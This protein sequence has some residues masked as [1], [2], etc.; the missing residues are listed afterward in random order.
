MKKIAITGG[1]S[2]GKTSVC[3]ILQACGAYVVSADEIV[4]RLLTPETAVGQEVIHL[5]GSE[6][7]SGPKIDRDKIAKKVFSQPELLNRLEQLLHPKVF[8]EIE[9]QY[10][11]ISKERKYT[12]FV[13]EIPLLFESESHHLFDLVIAVLTDEKLAKARYSDSTGK[14]DFESR[15]T[16]QIDPTRKA[17]KAD[18]VIQNNGSLEE[19]KKQVTHL[20]KTQLT[21]VK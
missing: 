8:D 2:S 13:A 12:L 9:K 21:S 16:R 14:T 19:L 17:I 18:F 1:L 11:K 10:Q 4:R 5:L 15:M 20:Y 7:L 6:I 3:H